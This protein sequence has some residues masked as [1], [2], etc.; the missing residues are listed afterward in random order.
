MHASEKGKVDV[1]KLLID[2]GADISHT[3]FTGRSVL[4]LARNSRSKHLV[5]LLESMGAN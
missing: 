5:K 4:D 1:V 2:H 3:D